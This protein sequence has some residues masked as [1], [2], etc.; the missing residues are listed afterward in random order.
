MNPPLPQLF[1]LRDAATHTWRQW[2]RSPLAWALFLSLALH[3]LL[4][5]LGFVPPQARLAAQKDEGLE[6]VLVNAYSRSRPEEAKALAQTSLAGGG[7]EK[8]APVP[9]TNQPPLE[10]ERP[11]DS[12]IEARSRP[13]ETASATKRKLSRPSPEKATPSAPEPT[14]PTTPTPSG[15]DLLDQTASVA[16]LHAALDDTE[17][18]VAGQPRKRFFGANVREYRFARYIEDWRLKV[19][20]IGTLNYPEEARGRLYGSLLMSVSIRADGELIDA[21]IERSSGQPVLDEAALRIVR[22]GAPYAPFPPEIRADTDVIVIKRTWTF[23]R[24]SRLQGN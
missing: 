12:P 15:L 17:R 11:S 18:A 1:S 14:A 7:T 22:L 20:R 4:L 24:E 5:S 2:R 16:R 9:T 13:Q 19:E 21:R 10:R 6:I 8:T 3:A 23:T